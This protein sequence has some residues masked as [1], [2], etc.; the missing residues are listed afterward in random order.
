MEAKV[1][2][3]SSRGTDNQGFG[4]MF[5]FMRIYN[6]E[7]PGRLEEALQPLDCPPEPN[8]L[9]RVNPELLGGHERV[10]DLPGVSQLPE[11]ELQRELSPT[12]S[13][14][15]LWKETKTSS[16]L[17][18]VP[19]GPHRLDHCSIEHGT[20]SPFLP[21]TSHHTSIICWN[22]HFSS[23]TLAY[24]PWLLG[25]DARAW[26]V[27]MPGL[28]VMSPDTRTLASGWLATSWTYWPVL[29]CE[30]CQKP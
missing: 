14:H 6:C 8:N 24:L 5:E 13:H 10:V 3:T 15:P 30:C 9:V 28:T 4:A 19:A 2:G 11:P 22:D 16:E 12:V 1:T 20:Y 25:P 21:V 7:T 29:G 26:R 27:Q 23:A 18:S 17:T